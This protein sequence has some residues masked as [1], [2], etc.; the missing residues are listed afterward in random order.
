MTGSTGASIN[1][2]GEAVNGSYDVI[3]DSV[4]DDANVS[5]LCLDLS[6]TEL[7]KK[8]D[9]LEGLVKELQSTSNEQGN[10]VGFWFGAR[11][12]GDIYMG[13]MHIHR[14]CAFNRGASFF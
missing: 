10:E 14:R 2:G 1:L 12:V 11:G 5:C 4:G 7:V 3:F 13:F 9:A 6:S 8:L